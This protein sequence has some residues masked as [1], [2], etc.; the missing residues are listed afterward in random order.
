MGGINKLLITIACIILPNAIDCAIRSDLFSGPKDEVEFVNPSESEV[1]V[2]GRG[3][4]TEADDMNQTV[5][6][7]MPSE[8]LITT[9]QDMPFS[10]TIMENG[11]LVG[12]G[13]A[14]YIFELLRSKMNFTYK[15]VLP[16]ESVLG[17]V[18]TGIFGQLVRKE[19]D[20]AVAFVPVVPEFRN[21]IKYSTELDEAEWT[22]LMKRPGESA[23]GSG[24]LAPFDTQ[25]WILIVISVLAA[26]P[27][28]YFLI[29]VRFLLCRDG[30][31][32]KYSLATCMWFVYG[33]L[34]KQG[35]TLSPVTDSA[36]LLF[37][38][39]WLFITVLTS[40]YTANLTAFLTLSQFTL[41]IGSASDLANKH[42]Q[43][44]A[45]KGNAIEKM[46]TQKDNDELTMLRRSVEK[47]YGIF[48]NLA[49]KDDKYIL[50]LVSSNKMYLRERSIVTSLLFNDYMNKTRDG[51]LESKR[52]TFVI[53]PGSIITKSQAF[54]FQL[55]TTIDAAINKR[56]LA[57]VE[58]GIISFKTS[59]HLPGT[60]ICPLNLGSTERQLRNSD[61]VMT[62]KGVGIGFVVA[63]TAFTVEVI[64][65][66]VIKR[67]KLRNQEPEL[68]AYRINVAEKSNF[69]RS[70]P[71]LYQN[72]HIQDYS[73]KQSINGRDYYIVREKD[74]EKR[75]VPVR[76]PSAFLF[77]YAA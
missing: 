34:L 22:I 37:A 35:S 20:M 50:D 27:T 12:V 64:Y 57:L 31:P 43:W 4:A 68:P 23:T 69:Q 53:M 73:K 74:G 77:Q 2:V 19:V 40:F 30:E 6:T 5:D 25:V 48:L 58:T 29:L 18:K 32:R 56:L 49:N 42:Q 46:I 55:N 3:A 61:L 21:L 15:I 45:E 14:F 54:A 38:T 36:R 52:C 24:L 44:I 8:L 75:L 66:L 13:Y 11:T 71:P 65:R 63:L 67:E 51:V 76:A 9:L 47:G 16:K 26:G 60:E 10:G 39:W 62:Y 7:N 41:P 70:P 17:D 1:D 72:I 28:L 59:E 33:A